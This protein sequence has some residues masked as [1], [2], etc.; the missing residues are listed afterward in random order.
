MKAV[1]DDVFLLS[2]FP[3]NAFNVYLMGGVLVDAGT[4]W[5]SRRITRQLTGRDVTANVLT[6][7]HQDH[8]GSSRVLHDSLGLPVWCGEGDAEAVETG[9][10]KLVNVDN[11]VTRMGA[12]L[13]AGP[14]VPVARRLKEGDE[15]GGF[16]V[17]DA[18]GHTPGQIGFWR[19]RDRVLVIGDAA[20]NISF[21]S[22]R[23]MLGELPS[24]L[25]V[26]LPKSRE[27]LHRLAAL[28]PALVLFGH[29]PPLR[30]AEKFVRFVEGLPR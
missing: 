20:R 22:G 17:L 13:W 30:K 2:G 27:T 9:N 25:C 15:V 8:Q 10:M 6:H 7:G 29:G 21:V 11:M 28:A 14:A 24:P 12:R 1:A 3:P 5:A 23:T 16:T 4:R 19:E 26:D 18:S